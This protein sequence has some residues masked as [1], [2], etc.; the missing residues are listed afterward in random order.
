M[1]ADALI[2]GGLDEVE[3][4]RLYEARLA[5]SIL[6]EL[7]AGRKLA[8]LFY[9]SRHVRDWLMKNYGERLTEAVADVYTGR[10]SYRSAAE[11]FLQRLQRMPLPGK[12]S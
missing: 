11:A 10:R 4:G 2:D 3:S 1:A 7:A 5:D 9:S 12:Q 8:T 6:P